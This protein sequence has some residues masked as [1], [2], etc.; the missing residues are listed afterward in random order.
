MRLLTAEEIASASV[1]TSIGL[2]TAYLELTQTGLGKSIMDATESVRRFLDQTGIHAYGNQAQGTEN[3]VLL[4]ARVVH[5]TGKIETTSV[6]LYRPETKN[7]DPRIWIYGLKSYAKAGDVVILTKIAG[8]LWVS[9]LSRSDLT[10][11]AMEANEFADALA[12]AFASK[13]LVVDDL[14]A[15]L[16]DIAARGFIPADGHGDTMVGRVLETELGIKANSSKSPDF[17][18][19]ELKAYRVKPKT[20]GHAMKRRNLFA[21]TPDWKTSPLKS[22]RQILDTFGYGAEGERRLYCEVRS[23]RF[24]TQ[25]LRLKVD[26]ENG[27]VLEVSDNAAF[28]TVALWPVGGLQDA[29]A[30]KHGET[31]WV[32]AESKKIDGQEHFRYFAVEHTQGPLVEQFAPLVAAGIISLD[33]LIKQKGASAVEKG[34]LFKIDNTSAGLLFPNPRHFRLDA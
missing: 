17:H 32:G 1:L 25:G 15:A 20:S 23:T 16:L 12:P 27:N 3:K 33:H 22:S 18:G 13:T 29:L 14:T 9:N 31:F 19:I 2:P 21:K 24:N 4:S 34:P 7:G 26:E 5:A 6:S 30:K 10:R 8:E 11:I 28:P